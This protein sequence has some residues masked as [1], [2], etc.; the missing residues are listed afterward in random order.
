MKRLTFD[1]PTHPRRGKQQIVVEQP[2]P[3]SVWYLVIEPDKAKP[4]VGFD[5]PPTSAKEVLDKFAKIYGEDNV[6]Q[7][8]AAGYSKP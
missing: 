8:M 7:F 1:L 3:T 5:E 4:L 2:D 6:A